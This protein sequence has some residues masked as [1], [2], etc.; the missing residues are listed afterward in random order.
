MAP[1][2]PIITLL[3]DFG[4]HDYFVGTMKGVI[5]NIHPEVTIVDISHDVSPHDIFQAAFLL[6]NAYTYFPIGT[7]HVVVVDPGV[8]SDRKP[9]IISSERGYFI[10]PDNGVLSYVYAE[11]HVSEIR[12]I[13]AD[14][15]FVK[16]R[17][18]TFDGRD[19]FAP[20]AAWLSK[21]VG[22]ALFG[23]PITEYK[24]FE[25][26]VPVKIQQ[27]ALKCTIV[28]VDR[29][30]NL[31]SNLTR[32][33]FKELLDSSKKRRFAFRVGNHNI[34][35]ISQS[36]AEGGED[37]LIA[38]FGSSGYVEFSV[39]QGNAAQFTELC[40]GKDIFLKVT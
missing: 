10:A 24:K 8:G 38:I 33:Q 34:S 39:N 36:Y 27:G 2:I 31:V 35:K 25:I 11:D 28:Y 5:M 37:E 9:I 13:T 23:E 19:I 32:E 7:I 26:S 16:P 15:Y 14:H 20:V 30:G 3:T 4:L 18:G 17:S 22:F 12:E 1:K 21:G 40:A 29:F 6:K